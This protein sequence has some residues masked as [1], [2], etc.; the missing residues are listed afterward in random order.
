MWHIVLTVRTGLT[1]SSATQWSPMRHSEFVFA[2]ACCLASFGAGCSANN[3]NYW[4]PRLDAGTTSQ[5]IGA[6]GGTVTAPDGTT[7]V[8]PAGALAEDVTITIMPNPF[9]PALTQ[10]QPLAVAH[11]FGPEGQ[12]FLKP[13]SVTVEFDPSSL[14]PGATA[15]GVS[16]Y[17]A[18][19]NSNFY[20]TLPTTVTDST[21]VT[22]RTSEFCNM[23]PGAN[24]GGTVQL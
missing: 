21:H 11:L 20:Q 14:P 19:S 7:V 22:A 15:Q 23:F 4:E 24:G 5:D 13:I 2:L 10:A 16:V 17:T 8:I 1:V 9:A 6:S 3:G 18:P 12:K